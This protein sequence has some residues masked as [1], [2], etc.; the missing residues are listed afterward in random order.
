MLS[1]VAEAVYWLSRYIERAENTA[2]CIDVNISLTLDLGDEW[3]NQWAPLVF[4]TGG[5][6]LFAEKHGEETT[7]ESVLQFLTYER[8]NPNSIFSCIAAARQNAR[9]VREALSTSVWE[10]LNK[11]YLRLN[12]ARLTGDLDTSIYDE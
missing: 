5:H 4:T 1:R 9:S 3:A 2:R 6:E 8:S 12:E 10:E 7:R 11:F